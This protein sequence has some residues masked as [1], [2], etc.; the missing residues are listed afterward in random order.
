MGIWECCEFLNEC[1]DDSDPDLDEPQIEHLPS[2]PVRLSG[3]TILNKIGF[4]SLHSSVD[5]IS[6]PATWQPPFVSSHII[7][8]KAKTR[9]GLAGKTSSDAQVS[10]ESESKMIIY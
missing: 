6:S 10:R 9:R 4:T 2:S 1:V 5:V 7:C 8:N 3:G